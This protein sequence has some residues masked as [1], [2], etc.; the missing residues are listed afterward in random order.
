MSLFQ[1]S[2]L[3]SFVQMQ[4]CPSFEAV[5]VCN[6]KQRACLNR[7][8]LCTPL[9]QR[10][11]YETRASTS[12]LVILKLVGTPALR[13]LS[14]IMFAFVA[15]AGLVGLVVFLVGGAIHNI[16][17]HPLSDVPGPRECAVS[18]VPYWYAYWHGRDARW[19]R[20]LHDKY[21]PVVRFGPNDLS[22]A[23]AQAWEDVNGPKNQDK[24]QEFSVQPVNG[25]FSA[26][27]SR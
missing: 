20:S 25:E 24:A 15:L 6:R 14:S 8:Y 21:G 5:G 23:V 27:N 10:Q 1:K 4:I 17:L 9:T 3:V 12:H 2:I 26:M 19:I 11:P 18:R 16:A 7:R 22:Y 13:F